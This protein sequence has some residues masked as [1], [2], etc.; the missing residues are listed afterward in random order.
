MPHADKK[1]AHCFRWTY[2]KKQIEILCVILQTEY[3]SLEKRGN[4]KHKTGEC[5]LSNEKSLDI[6]YLME[7]YALFEDLE[8]HQDLSTHPHKVTAIH[9]VF[10]ITRGYLVK[11]GYFMKLQISHFGGLTCL[12][13]LH[14]KLQNDNQNKGR[15]ICTKKLKKNRL[16]TKKDVSKPRTLPKSQCKHNPACFLN[17]GRLFCYKQIDLVEFVMSA[18]SK[19]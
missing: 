15:R 17:V 14:F 1:V 9:I 11:I 8:D 13:P 5:L 10:G 2:T 3:H 18:W 12:H 4:S 19:R 16:F 7:T 6:S